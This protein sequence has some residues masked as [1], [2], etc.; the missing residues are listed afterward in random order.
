MFSF[1]EESVRGGAATNL[2][3]GDRVHFTAPYFD[4]LLICSL[5]L[6]RSRGEEKNESYRGDRVHLVCL[7]CTPR[8]FVLARSVFF[9]K[10]E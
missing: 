8:A 2:G 7:I 9:L 10:R 4:T 1:L 6:K 3:R 5:F